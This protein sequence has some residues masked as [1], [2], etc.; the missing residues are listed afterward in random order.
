M[1]ELTKNRSNN[2]TDTRKPKN[3]VR[4][5]ATTTNAAPFRK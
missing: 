3:I 2:L 5:Q 4:H 1:K